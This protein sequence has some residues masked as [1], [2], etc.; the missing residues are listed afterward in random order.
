MSVK[1]GNEE[2]NQS[3][4]NQ[5]LEEQSKHLRNAS[6]I[7]KPYYNKSHKDIPKYV[8]EQYTKEIHKAAKYANKCVDMLKSD[9]NR[10]KQ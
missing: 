3:V 4:I 6:N 2:N 9:K 5:I 7:I 10:S 8:L 1:N